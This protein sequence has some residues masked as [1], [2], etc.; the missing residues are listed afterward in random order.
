MAVL[1]NKSF[2]YLQLHC[3]K[4]IL[5]ALELL[6]CLYQIQKQ[7]HVGLEFPSRP[8]DKSFG[9]GQT[10]GHLVVQRKVNIGANKIIEVKYN[11][12][13]YE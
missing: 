12:E 5:L 11:L 1:L 13:S 8:E 9:E 4:Q 7:N 6:P 10:E 3:R 2:S